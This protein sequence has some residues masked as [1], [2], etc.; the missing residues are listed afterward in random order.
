MRTP[1]EVA[2]LIAAEENPAKRATLQAEF[3]ALQNPVQL[4][5]Q[6]PTPVAA[7]AAPK[8]LHKKRRPK[9]HKKRRSRYTGY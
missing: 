1:V 5:E 3:A 4:N 6:A 8:P 9:L 2:A 7:P